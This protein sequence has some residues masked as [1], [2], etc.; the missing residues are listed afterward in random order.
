MRGAIQTG[1]NH[2]SHY[3]GKLPTAHRD[4]VPNN[5]SSMMYVTKFI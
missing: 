1:E 5:F 3:L 2:I 4:L